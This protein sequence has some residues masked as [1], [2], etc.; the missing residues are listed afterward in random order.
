MDTTIITVCNPW[1]NE[2]YSDKMKVTKII[3][4][5]NVSESE[6]LDLLKKIE[7]DEEIE[8]TSEQLQSLMCYGIKFMEK[9]YETK[10]EKEERLIKIRREEQEE[11]EFFN[12]SMKWFETLTDEQKKMV[13]TLSF[14][15]FQLRAIA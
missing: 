14:R 11:E 7:A 3:G 6:A 13:E 12:L 9:Y 15:L 8:F 5:L 1:Y 10:K 2:D 4:A